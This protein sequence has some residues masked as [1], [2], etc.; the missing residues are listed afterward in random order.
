VTDLNPVEA[1]LL[2]A[3]LDPRIPAEQVPA[4][5]EQRASWAGRSQQDLRSFTIDRVI[6]WGQTA[7]TQGEILAG[8]ATHADEELDDVTVIEREADRLT[9]RWR[10]EVAHFELRAGLAGC[11]ALAARDEPRMLLSN[12]D[13]ASDGF[14]ETFAGDPVMR[15]GLVVQDLNRLEKLGTAR[16]SVFVHF[17]WFL[18]DVYG[19]KLLNTGEFTQRLIALGVISLG[20]G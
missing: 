2:E 17:E 20:M 4:T 5:P 12:L 3:V 10:R 8:F 6:E 13:L 7:T 14:I 1:E 11:A 9:L 16:A 19:V 18:R 15:N